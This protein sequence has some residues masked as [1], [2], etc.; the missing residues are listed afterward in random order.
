MVKSDFYK[1]SV[2]KI[3]S[4][5]FEHC[6]QYN[7]ATFSEPITDSYAVRLLPAALPD[8]FPFFPR[9]QPNTNDKNIIC[10]TLKSIISLGS[11]VLKE[12]FPHEMG[13][14]LDI[15]GKPRT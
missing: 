7:A 10:D 4:N 15:E 9:A 11:G 8:S 6:G 5:V 2:L 12:G 1:V 13:L 3:S 14:E